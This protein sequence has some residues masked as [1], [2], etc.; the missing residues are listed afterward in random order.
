M[1][2][3]TMAGFLVCAILSLSAAV[4]AQKAD[5]S[6]WGGVVKYKTYEPW[7]YVLVQ[8][9]NKHQSAQTKAQI[10]SFFG[11]TNAYE[12]QEKALTTQAAK[13][14]KQAKDTLDKLT[15]ESERETVYDN[16]WL[17]GDVLNSNKILG[18]FYTLKVSYGNLF[19]HLEPEYIKAAHQLFKTVIG[20]DPT[21][22][23]K[24]PEPKAAWKTPQGMVWVQFEIKVEQEKDIL[25][26]CFDTRNYTLELFGFEKASKQDGDESLM[27]LKKLY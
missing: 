23:N 15:E 2:K 22:R 26:F 8:Q 21:E 14:I 19:Y 4:W 13:N 1:K 11:I 17:F 18:K 24:R 16:Y 12:A 7:Y 20:S 27:D 25:L 10:A 3:L 9:H 5:V 6:Y